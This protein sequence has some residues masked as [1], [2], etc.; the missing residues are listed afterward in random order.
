MRL[1]LLQK[2]RLEP[3]LKILIS[4]WVVYHLAG[5]V[6]L[7]NG[8]SFL[9]RHFGP[10][11]LYYANAIG[12]NNAWNFFSPEPPPTLYFE[13]K[14]TFPLAEG[15]SSRETLQGFFPP[16]KTNVVLNTS[17]RRRLYAMEY[18]MVNP[19]QIDALVAP[20][21]CRSYP[22]AAEVEITHKLLDLPTLDVA[23][24]SISDPVESLKRARD[25]KTVNYNCRTGETGGLQ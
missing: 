9:G 3:A 13:Y 21:L 15:K 11:F 19:M 22:N 7:P 6:I 25:M 5:I 24:A 16:E 14:I 8:G 10:Y 18:L 23:I 17:E 4:V 20:W 1:P 2:R 12:A